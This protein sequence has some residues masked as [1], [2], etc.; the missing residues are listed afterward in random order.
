MINIQTLGKNDKSVRTQ[1]TLTKNIKSA[2]EDMASD[3]GE[4]LSEFLRKAALIRLMLE[5]EERESLANLA[6]KVIGSIKLEG[7]P[8]WS[9]KKAI[10][11]WSREIRRDKNG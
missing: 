9:S 3:R 8:N 5:R 10:Y 11:K 4:S 7:H 1:I 6:K 2:V